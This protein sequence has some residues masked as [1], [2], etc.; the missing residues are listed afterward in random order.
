MWKK[1]HYSISASYTKAEIKKL[2]QEL[3]KYK[4]IQILSDDIYE[5]ITY[6]K[7][8]FFTIAQISNLK[9]PSYNSIVRI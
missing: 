8:K 4:K 9:N 1:K 6:D 5:H 7:A 2:S 3:I